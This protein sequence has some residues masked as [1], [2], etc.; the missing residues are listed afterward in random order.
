M[1]S[2]RLYP[3]HA[4]LEDHTEKAMNALQLRAERAERERDDIRDALVNG[5]WPECLRWMGHD[6]DCEHH[7]SGPDTCDCGSDALRFSA[8]K[9]LRDLAAVEAA[10]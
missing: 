4:N 1:T 8:E 10:K 9:L 3:K 5:I 7:E 2:E 6:D